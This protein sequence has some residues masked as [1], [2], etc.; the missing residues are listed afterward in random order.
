MADEKIFMEKVIYEKTYPQ[1]ILDK[2]EQV[3]AVAGSPANTGKLLTFDEFWNILCNETEYVPLPER[4]KTA[5]H[6]KNTAIEISEMYELDIKIKQTQS[7][8]SVNYYFNSAGCMGFLKDILCLADDITFFANI[9][10]YEIVMSLDYYT[11]AVYRRGK[12][13][14]P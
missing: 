4:E 6:F 13:I 10:G 3:P 14:E 8:L 12:R 9:Q 7:H 1:E 5:E 2:C 11:H